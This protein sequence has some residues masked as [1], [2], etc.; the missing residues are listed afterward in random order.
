MPAESLANILRPPVTSAFGTMTH[1]ISSIV[2]MAT[3][4][5]FVVSHRLPLA[6]YLKRKGFRVIVAT[7]IDIPLAPRLAQDFEFREIPFQRRGTNPLSEAMT[8]LS[9]WALYR[10]VHPALVHHF[11]HKPILYGGLAARMTGIASVLGTV[12]GLGYAYVSPGRKARLVR[13]L[14]RVL[15]RSLLRSSSS[16]LIFQNRDDQL[17]F[18]ANGMAAPGRSTLIRGSGVDCR[19]FHPTDPPGSR[20]PVVLSHSRMLWSKGIGEV[21]EAARLLKQRGIQARFILAGAAGDENPQSI[22]ESMLRAWQAE[23]LVEWVGVADDM[24]RLLATARVVCLPSHREGL[25]LALVEALASGVPVVTTDVPGCRDVVIDGD[26]GFL[27][28]LRSPLQLAERIAKLLG[29]SELC[30]MMGRSGRRRALERFEVN[31]V[32]E[33]TYALYC[34]CILRASA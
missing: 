17:F 30:T 21:V 13:A 8:L 23:G 24:P 4:A 34:H 12:T 31:L 6:Y 25:P 22:P 33:Q 15:Y 14:L 1:A 29:N 28:P 3:H 16:Y 20:L 19:R 10:R 27:V 5:S 26:S 7:H 9:I 32:V 18:E 11:G 2:L